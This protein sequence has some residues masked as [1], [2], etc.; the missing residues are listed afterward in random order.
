MFAKW[1]LSHNR[2]NAASYRNLKLFIGILGMALPLILVVGG[3]LYPA[4]TI[5]HS[6]SH[7]Y[8]TDLRDVLVGTLA[9]AS[10]LFMTY[11]GYGI[12][13]DILTWAVGIAGIGVIV[14]PCPTFPEMP[15]APVGIFRLPQQ[16]SGPIHFGCAGAFFLLLAI[17]SIFL[18]TLS[19]KRSVGDAK[20]NRNIVYIV[21]G[22]V[23]LA[24]LAA[25]LVL[26]LAAK[27]FFGN[28]SVALVFEAVMLLA[29]GF[30]WLVKADIGLFRDAVVPAKSRS[31]GRRRS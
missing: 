27:D 21:C 18:F 20:R 24:C 11:A 6:V 19:D 14:F 26:S 4:H 9:S 16:L 7:Y 2:S 17:N 28:S 29:F 15:Q 13:D 31:R 3:L 8:H 23:I 1:V 12:I 25:L 22:A 30:A 5:Q 10:I